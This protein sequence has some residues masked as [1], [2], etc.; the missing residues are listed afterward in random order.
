MFYLERGE[1]N[2][3]SGDGGG[4]LGLVV[5]EDIIIFG[6]I[7]YKILIVQLNKI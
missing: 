5:K 6:I 2:W 1:W 3:G 7:M 4:R